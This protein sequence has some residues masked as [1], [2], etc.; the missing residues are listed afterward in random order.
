MFK[1]VSKTTVVSDRCLLLIIFLTCQAGISFSTGWWFILS[2]SI[3]PTSPYYWFVY[4]VQPPAPQCSTTLITL[5]ECFL[6]GWL[7]SQY[8][9][10]IPPQNYC[11]FGLLYTD[12]LSSCLR[13]RTTA[14]FYLWHN[15]ATQAL[16]CAP[17]EICVLQNSTVVI[18]PH[19]SILTDQ[20]VCLLQLCLRNTVY[21]F[22][23]KYLL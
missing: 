23:I 13:Q 2:T 7:A 5:L 3:L 22:L 17:S 12:V 18:K 8:I 19:S 20:A 21:F 14:C 9:T 4:P 16:C 11:I 10:I 1:F 15:S 6:P